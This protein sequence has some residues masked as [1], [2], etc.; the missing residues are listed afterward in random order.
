MD[1]QKKK[2]FIIHNKILS[3]HKKYRNL[4]ICSNMDHPLG[5]TMQIIV[6]RLLGH[7]VILWYNSEK[8]TCYML[9]LISKRKK[10]KLIETE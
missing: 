10:A 6:I 8:D 1:E 2:T 7:W 3:S 5:H 9:S 4:A